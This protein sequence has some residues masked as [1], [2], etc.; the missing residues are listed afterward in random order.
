MGTKEETIK[1]AGKV[2]PFEFFC[3]KSEYGFGFEKKVWIGRGDW[4][5]KLDGSEIQKSALKYRGSDIGTGF[6]RSGA[7]K[8]ASFTWEGK[9][10]LTISFKIYEKPYVV[11][12]VK[13]SNL[14]PGFLDI[15][16][17]MLVDPSTFGTDLYISA[18][19]S[20]GVADVWPIVR[21]YKPRDSMEKFTA[22]NGDGREFLPIW[23]YDEKY[24]VVMLP[25]DHFVDTRFV[26]IKEGGKK[27]FSMRLSGRIRQDTLETSALICYSDEGPSETLIKA[28]EALRKIYGRPIPSKGSFSHRHLGYSTANGAFYF[29]RLDE[30]LI[31]ALVDHFQEESVPVRWVHLDVMWY[32]SSGRWPS[33]PVAVPF[34]ELLDYINTLWAVREF[35]P[36]EEAFPN[37]FRNFKMPIGVWIWSTKFDKDTLYSRNYPWIKEGNIPE[38]R[39]FW[40]DVAKDFKRHNMVWVEPDNLCSIVGIDGLEGIGEK[41]EWLTN[42]IEPFKEYNIPIQLCMCPSKLYPVALRTENAFFI[43]T[44]HDFRMWPDLSE[45][46]QNFYNTA[47]AWAFGLYPCFDVFYTSEKS[48]SESEEFDKR[49]AP[50]PYVKAPNVQAEALAHALS[51]GINY[52]GDGIG[53]IDKELVKRLCLSNGEIIHPDRPAFPIRAC[54]HEDPLEDPHPLVVYTMLGRHVLV[55]VFNLSDHE[56][57]FSVPL[58]HVGA[59]G[60]YYAFGWFSRKIDLV[61]D[62]ISGTIRPGECELYILCPALRNEFAVVGDLEKFVAPYVLKDECMSGKTLITTVEIVD[63]ANL[64]IICKAPKEVTVNGRPWKEWRYKDGLLEMSLSPGEHVIRVG[65]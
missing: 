55:G 7:Y 46:Y 30:K 61:K 65:S 31:L 52:I 25:M 10:G 64:G 12:S 18:L 28:G 50:I 47:L 8:C 15:D 4:R 32:K 62:E 35:S 49:N 23:I 51:C 57:T 36:D 37:S 6:D 43:R 24:S 3:D 40:L 5:I 34:D 38:G 39:D 59:N 45:I 48:Y 1:F 17:P 58:G 11:A 22:S 19:E 60:A 33:E 63:R 42:L 44:G 27:G 26:S 20:S 41:E 21:I 54:Y 2:Y 9:V 16:F 29:N 14:T 56:E 53:L 13:V